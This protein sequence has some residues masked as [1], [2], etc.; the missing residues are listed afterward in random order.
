MRKK[1]APKPSEPRS[2]VTVGMLLHRKGGP[3]R[4]RRAR[5]PRDAERR[6]LLEDV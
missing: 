1:A 3:M 2:M 4:D 5:R 6:A